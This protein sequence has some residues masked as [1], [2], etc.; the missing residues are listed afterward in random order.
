M[1]GL[2]YLFVDL[3]HC[4]LLNLLPDCI[5]GWWG[6][7][8]SLCPKCLMKESTFKGK[9]AHSAVCSG[10]F[11]GTFRTDLVGVTGRICSCDCGPLCPAS[12]PIRDTA[13]FSDVFSAED[14]FY[15]F[16]SLNTDPTQRDIPPQNWEFKHHN[17]E[18]IV[19]N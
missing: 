10:L 16:S 17:E 5:L 2:I 12:S 6:R 11:T 7:A 3:S 13:K 9:S 8:D 15:H 14:V 19:M 18:L 4:Y 1:S